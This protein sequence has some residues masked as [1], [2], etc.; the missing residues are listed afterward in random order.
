M[1]TTTSGFWYPDEGTAFNIN[2]IMSTT[3]SSLET[4]VG[5]HVLDTGWVDCPLVS[6]TSQQGASLPQVRR[7]GKTVQMRWG[8]S[9]TGK[10]ANSS[11]NV[12]TVPVGFRPKDWRY[13]TAASASTNVTPRIV[14]RG[15][16]LVVLYVPSSTSTYYIFDV[17]HWTID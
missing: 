11:S 16:G 17:A 2:T 8:V 10:A 12:C 9:G 1:A 4:K 3:V 14:V 7:I 15:D 13:F 6:G 5:P